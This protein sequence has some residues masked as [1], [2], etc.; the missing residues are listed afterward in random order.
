[1][2][3]KKKKIDVAIP[4]SMLRVSLNPITLCFSGTYK[5]LEKP[6]REAYF[7]NSLDHVRRCK[8]YAALFF[9]I[10][11][12]LDV[13]VFPDQLGQLL[14]IRFAIVCPIFLI[15]LLFFLHPGLPAGVAVDE[16]VLHHGD[17]ICLRGDGH[18]HAAA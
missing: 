2:N 4:Y 7:L 8:L 12:L 13:F 11:G 5:T 17:W 1:M 6:F 14:F 10:F 18:D 3:L 9:G 15:G 16:C